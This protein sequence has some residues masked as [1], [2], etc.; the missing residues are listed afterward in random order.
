M[1]NTK[2]AKRFCCENITLIENYDKAI[3]DETQTWD[4]HHR[5][6]LIVTG[7]V[8]DVAR[9]DLIDWN[10]YYNR[11]ADELIFMTKSEHNSIHYNTRGIIESHIGKP[12]TFKGRSH[13]KET[14][15]KMSKAH[16]GRKF[17]KEWRRKMSESAKKRW[18]ITRRSSNA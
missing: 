14:K 13:T 3:A 7:G 4:C 1:I 10:L 18:A 15:L 2:N 9:Q 17:S 6:E 16:K 5:L 12:S 11:P 8:C